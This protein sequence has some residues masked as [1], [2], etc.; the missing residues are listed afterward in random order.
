MVITRPPKP[1][2]SEQTKFS[3]P[4]EYSSLH[5]RQ[6]NKTFRNWQRRRPTA[7]RSE[8][9]REQR[10]QREQTSILTREKRRGREREMRRQKARQCQNQT[11]TLRKTNP[12]LKNQS[13]TRSVDP[14]LSLVGN[15]CHFCAR[16]S[17]YFHFDPCCLLAQVE[18]PL[19]ASELEAVVPLFE[20]NQS[21]LFHHYDLGSKP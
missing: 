5:S 11:K 17:R 14:A 7:S 3:P 15:Q 2:M 20:T 21:L 8:T 13:D 4:L 1:D 10:E 16:E 9:A 18:Y 19:A 12:K 6:A